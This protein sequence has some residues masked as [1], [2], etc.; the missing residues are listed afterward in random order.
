[1]ALQGGESLVLHQA[2][3]FIDRRDSRR[4]SLQMGSPEGVGDDDEHPAHDVTRS[5]YCIDKTEVTVKSYGV[6]VAAGRC[7][8]AHVEVSPSL[9]LQ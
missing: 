3:R 7:A 2:H 8:T 5:P 1:M 6:C 4:R 9:M